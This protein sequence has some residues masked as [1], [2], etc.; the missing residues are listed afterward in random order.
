METIIGTLAT[1]ISLFSFVPQVYRCW[2]TKQTKDISFT[3]F[4]ILATGALLWASYGL[5]RNDIP[6]IF[7]NSIVFLLACS[8]LVMKKKYG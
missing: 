1:V 6:V 7:T 5:L 3:S 8:I 4:S 2:K